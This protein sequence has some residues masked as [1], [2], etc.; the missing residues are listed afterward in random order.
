MSWRCATLYTLVRD[1]PVYPGLFSTFTMPV[2]PTVPDIP[3]VP[4]IPAPIIYAT[5]SIQVASIPSHFSSIELLDKTTNNWTWWKH[6]ITQHLKL[7]GLASY[8]TGSVACPTALDNLHGIANWHAN[9]ETVVVILSIKCSEEEQDFICNATGAKAIWDIL[10]A[11]YEKEG[12]IMQILLIQ[13]FFNM[14]YRCTEPYSITSS[15]S[16][17]LVT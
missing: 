6:L 2:A 5:P 3:A 10:Q 12:L 4:A 7:I 8:L 14:C 15:K 9:D 16:L 11:R 1:L 13:E 17:N